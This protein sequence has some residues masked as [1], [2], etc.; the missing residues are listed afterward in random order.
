MVDVDDYALS[1]AA[2]GMTHDK[3]RCSGMLLDFHFGGCTDFCPGSEVLALR[4]QNKTIEAERARDVAGA[5]T[6]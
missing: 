1:C 4:M 5:R 6:T 2:N 3:I